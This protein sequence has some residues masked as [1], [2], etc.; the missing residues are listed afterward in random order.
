MIKPKLMMNI[1][2]LTLEIYT[3][4]ILMFV[5]SEVRILTT[6]YAVSNKTEMIFQIMFVF[7]PKHPNNETWENRFQC[8]IA[9]H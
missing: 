4:N 9:N 6:N 2:K 1:C 8:L 5:K 7:V 3:C